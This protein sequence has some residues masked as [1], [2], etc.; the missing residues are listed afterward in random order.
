MARGVSIDSGL[1]EDS[2]VQL[3]TVDTVLTA[4]EDLAV[5][6]HMDLFSVIVELKLLI[7]LHNQVFTSEE[8]DEQND[9]LEQ[10]H[11]E[12]VLTHL[13]G[14]HKIVFALRHTV[15]KVITRQFC[16]KGE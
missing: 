14:D 11:V 2:F 6:L 3:F 8:E 15:K 4:R 13:A 1:F 9:H 7:G 10:R 5:L 16:G 12:D